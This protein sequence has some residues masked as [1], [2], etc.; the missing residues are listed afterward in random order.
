MQNPQVLLLPLLVAGSSVA[1]V[2]A[3]I[4]LYA[5]VPALI[6]GRVRALRVYA[7][8]LLL[9]T[10]PLLPWVTYLRRLPDISSTLA[11]GFERRDE[12]EHLAASDDCR[13]WG[14]VHQWGGNGRHGS[15]CPA[16]GLRRSGTTRPS[17][18]RD[19]L[20]IAAALAAVPAQGFMVAALVVAALEVRLLRV[21]ALS[22]PDRGLP[23]RGKT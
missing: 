21:R 8:V 19:L 6:Q 22:R 12:R 17:Q 10:A 2:A 9:V 20:P 1:A 23:E 7:A 16:Y 4:K 5:G 3:L 14:A 18:S 15:Q 11:D 13:D